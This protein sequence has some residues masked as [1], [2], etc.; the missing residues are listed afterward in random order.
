MSLSLEIREQV[1]QRA[2]RAC[3]FCGVSEVDVGGLLTIDHFHPQS[4]GGSD[5]LDNL[6]YCC[7]RCNQYKQDYWPTCEADP[8]LWNPRQG[9]T[10]G[11]F[12]ELEDGRVVGISSCGEFTILRLRLNRAPLVE[13]RMR[14]R[15]QAEQTRLLQRYRDLVALLTQANGQLSDLLLEQQQLLQEQ[16]DLLRFL[17]EQQE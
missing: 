13:Y 16:R 1:R 15:Q 3:E 7:V 10:S 11:N 4:K 2:R 6:I 8:M 9:N 5:D 12:V 14:R 17:L